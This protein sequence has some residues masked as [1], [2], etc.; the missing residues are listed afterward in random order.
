M[1]TNINFKWKK[2]HYF[3][4]M[5]DTVTSSCLQIGVMMMNKCAKLQSHMSMDFE[6]I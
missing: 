2:G 5:I 4:K 3:A 6:N 1:L